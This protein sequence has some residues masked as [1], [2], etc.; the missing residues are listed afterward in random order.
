MPDKIKPE[1]NSEGYDTEVDAQIVIPWVFDPATGEYV[2]STKG[3]GAFGGGSVFVKRNSDG[4]LINPAREED[5]TA[6]KASV[7]GISNK[8]STEATLELVR[9]L[10]NLIHQVAQSS[11]TLLESI[12]LK[13]ATETTLALLNGKVATETKLEAVRSLLESIR[14]THFRRTDPL[15]TGSNVIGYVTPSSVADV[16]AARV[17][18]VSTAE[19]VASLGQNI[20][21]RLQNPAGSNKLVIISKIVAN[22]L[23]DR[24]TVGQVFLNPTAGLPTT[25]YTPVNHSLGGAACSA[26]FHMDA[27]A[28]ALSGGTSLHLRPVAHK[29]RV[30]ISISNGPI[31]LSPGQSFGLN[32][33]LGALQSGTG[34]F[35]MSFI[36]KAIV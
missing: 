14:D 19:I 35:S 16:L 32:I 31:I 26:L 6:L 25:Q 21:G 34:Q 10:L 17:F 1:F 8:V 30:E 7:D 28:T 3:E 27:G 12:D 24:M 29:G 20:R 4:A 5:I 9:S 11:D 15:A 13:A 2:V 18:T 36:E 22:Q 33:P 23:E